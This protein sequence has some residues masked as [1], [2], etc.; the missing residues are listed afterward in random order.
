[1]FFS[2]FRKLKIKINGRKERLFPI[3]I[4]KEEKVDDLKNK[5]EVSS[6]TLD[7]T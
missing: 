7:S 2:F 5:N 6:P 3:L 4:K 1:M